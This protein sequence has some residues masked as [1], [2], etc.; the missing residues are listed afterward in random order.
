[1]LGQQPH[2]KTCLSGLGT[3]LVDVSFLDLGPENFDGVQGIRIR[4]KVVIVTDYG[5]FVLARTS[6]LAPERLRC[7]A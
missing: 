5:F 4:E 1:M 7:D 3:D 2:I 6:Y